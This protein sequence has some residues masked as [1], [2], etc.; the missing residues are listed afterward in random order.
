[1]LPPPDEEDK[2]IEELEGDLMIEEMHIGGMD[3]F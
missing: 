2:A 1:M 3:D